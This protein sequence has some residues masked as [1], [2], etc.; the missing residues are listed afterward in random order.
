MCVRSH[1]IRIFG[2][3]GAFVIYSCWIVLNIGKKIVYASLRSTSPS[4]MILGGMTVNS[5]ATIYH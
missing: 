5:W 2:G 4:I 3:W 1:S